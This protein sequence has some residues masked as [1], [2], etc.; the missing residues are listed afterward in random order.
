MSEAGSALQEHRRPRRR[1]GRR[2]RTRERDL[3]GATKRRID[4]PERAIQAADTEESE[5]LRRVGQAREADL[6]SGVPGDVEL[7][8]AHL[9]ARGVDAPDHGKDVA[10]YEHVP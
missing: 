10:R 2:N 1:H 7:V 5:L 9:E 8:P 3:L 6:S 4:A